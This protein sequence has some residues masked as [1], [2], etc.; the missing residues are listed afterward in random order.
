MFLSKL[1]SV[2]LLMKKVP[3]AGIFLSNSADKNTSN[4]TLC[5]HF[6]VEIIGRR[7]IHILYA[8]SEIGRLFLH[9][10]FDQFIVGQNDFWEMSTLTKVRL[11]RDNIIYMQFSMS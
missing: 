4:F 3:F 9:C 8:S 11:S 2:L 6:D 7:N 5:Y 10:Q 1:V